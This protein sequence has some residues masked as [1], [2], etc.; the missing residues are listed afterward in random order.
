[1]TKVTTNQAIDNWG[2]ICA[3]NYKL[4]KRLEKIQDNIDACM[5]Y[6]SYTNNNIILRP[7]LKAQFYLLNT[8]IGEIEKSIPDYQKEAKEAALNLEPI[9]V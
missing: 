6:E 1:M 2:H 4:T 3:L 9:N 5:D 7:A 8:I